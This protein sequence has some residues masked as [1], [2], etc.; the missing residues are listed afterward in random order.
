MKTFSYVF[1]FT[2]IWLAFAQNC[3]DKGILIYKDIKCKTVTKKV[4]CATSF[5]CGFA[6]IRSGCLFK[7]KVHKE[8]ENIPYD[9]AY[10]SCNAGCSCRG[11][12]ILCDGTVLNS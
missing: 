12:S 5:D 7:G 4:R 10:S 1:A 8:Q 6:R 2:I 3:D 9:L 11:S